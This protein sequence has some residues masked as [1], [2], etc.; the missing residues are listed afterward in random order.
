M[1]PSSLVAAVV[2]FLACGEP[3]AAP[4]DP[5]VPQFGVRAATTCPTA[6]DVVVTDEAGLLAALAAASPGDVIALDGFFEVTAAV[7]IGTDGITLTCATP[8]SGLA[9][10]SGAGVGF[11]L[12][13]RG[14]RIAVDHL[15]LDGS[16]TTRGPYEAW[17]DGGIRAAEDPRLTNSR[18]TCGPDE[19][20]FFVGTPRAIV[21]DN[22]FESATSITGVH[23]QGSGGRTDGSRVERNTIVATAPSTNPLFGGIRARDGSGLV[24][25][26]NVV[27]GP[28]AN[29]L[30]PSEV[31]QSVIEGNWLIRAASFGIRTSTNA[32]VD[33][34]S[35]DNVFR[36]NRAALAG[37]AGAFVFRACRNLFSGNSF[38]GN[39]GNLGAIF[40]VS[41]GA[42]TLVGNQT[43][44]IDNGAFDCDGD[45]TNDPN[46]ITGRGAVQHGV[47]LGE[48]VSEVIVAS[49]DLR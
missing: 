40:D 16:A 49:N 41:S 33:I 45:G 11:L 4:P 3:T 8:G 28:W 32:L 39:A 17:F 43:V 25:A 7:F 6:P 1:R 29:S 24:I 35:A 18:V 22:H 13:V 44:V 14:R 27:I 20:A 34:S 2:A 9:A 31:S 5:A 12:R 10:Q 26:S 42:N 23:L 36:N 38:Q 15:V 19:C 30:S 21:S 37:V 47:N 48:M 46:I